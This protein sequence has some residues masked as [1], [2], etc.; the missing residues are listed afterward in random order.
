LGNVK[1]LR[2]NFVPK[3]E[4]FKRTTLLEDSERDLNESIYIFKSIDYQKGLADALQARGEL[5]ISQEKFK[6]ARRDWKYLSLLMKAL[7]SLLF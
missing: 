3:Q 4:K 6:S 5:Y 2:A 7:H 1:R